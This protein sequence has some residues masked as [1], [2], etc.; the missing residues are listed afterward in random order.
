MAP[1]RLH[2]QTVA[3]IVQNLCSFTSREWYCRWRD[4]VGSN[5]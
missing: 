4:V 1:F 3:V 5:I 2:S